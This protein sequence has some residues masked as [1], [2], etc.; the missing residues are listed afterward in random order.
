LEFGSKIK[1]S[2]GNKMRKKKDMLIA[3]IEEPTQTKIIW[4]DHP[5]QIIKRKVV[6]QYGKEI[7]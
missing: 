3:I 2:G 4:R 1:F 6:D 5:I 7:K